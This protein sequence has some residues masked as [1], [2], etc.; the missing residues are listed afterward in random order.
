MKSRTVSPLIW[1]VASTAAIA[2]T[3]L[4]AR[5]PIDVNAA[6]IPVSPGLL[7]VCKGT[8]FADFSGSSDGRTVSVW[9]TDGTSSG[10][11]KL[12]DLETTADPVSVEC[13]LVHNGL[14]YF[15]FIG[16]D[17][18]AALWRTD[19]TAAG[20]LRL[21]RQPSASE[22]P[23]RLAGVLATPIFV[24]SIGSSGNELVATDGTVQGTRL[25]A[26]I[27]NGPDASDIGNEFAIR[28][29]RLYFALGAALWTTDGT[30]AGTVSVMSLATT[31]DPF[32]QIVQV[33]AIN[34]VIYALSREQGTETLWRSDG[35]AG[36]TSVLL[37][38]DRQSEGFINPDFMGSPSGSMIFML[39]PPPFAGGELWRTDG[40]IAGTN[41][42]SVTEPDLSLIF[43]PLPLAN[44]ELAFIGRTAR[45]GDELWI[46]DG[47]DVGTRLVRDL[48]PGPDGSNI[49]NL[50]AVGTGVM[51]VASN[52]TAG[53]APW[54]SDGTAS[55]TFDVGSLDTRL[56]SFGFGSVLQG[57]IGQD[58]YF[59]TL[60]FGPVGEIRTSLLWRLNPSTRTV[61]VAAQLSGFGP[62]LILSSL[63]GRLM[64]VWDDP[65]LGQELWASDGTPGGTT[66]VADLAPQTQ[67]GNADPGHLF[68]LGDAVIYAGADGVRTR[69]LWRSDGTAGGTV[70]VAD[71]APV[72]YTV[73]PPHSA[74]FLGTRLVY[75]GAA[76]AN[77][78]E[79]WIT[80]GTS[81]GT[82]RLT[83]VTVAD[84][85]VS[86][87]FTDASP[88]AC[89]RGF[90]A[91]GG[92]VYFGATV[93]RFGRLYR[94]DGTPIGTT[95]IGVYPFFSQRLFNER[96][97]V[98]P[99]ASLGDRIF[100][101]ASDPGEPGE[102]LWRADLG[103]LNAE[104][105]Q[106]TS[107]R[108]LASPEQIAQLGTSLYFYTRDSGSQRGWWRVS[109]ATGAAE[110]VA[111]TPP[112]ALGQPGRIVATV[113]SLIYFQECGASQPC[114]LSRT[115]GTSA[116]TFALAPA[117]F[118][119]T[120]GSSVTGI[121]GTQILFQ[122]ATDG[123]LWITDGTR[124]GTRLLF[125]IDVG[126]GPSE[127][128]SFVN[129]RGLVYFVVRRNLAPGVTF[130]LWRTDGTAANTERA[131]ALPQYS[132][133]IA[134]SGPPSNGMVTAGQRL[135]LPLYTEAS[136][137]ELWNVENEAPVAQADA[138]TSAAGN[139][140]TV[141]VLANDRDNDGS[142]NRA[143]VRIVQA[144]TSGTT[145]IDNA[146][147][148]IRFTP[149]AS[150][151]GTITF[152]YVVADIQ[153]RESAPA[154]VTVTVTAPPPSGGGNGGS[155]G[156]GGGGA[157]D[158]FSL[159]LLLFA[160]AAT[161]NR[162]RAMAGFR[163]GYLKSLA[164]CR[165]GI[166]SAASPKL[167]LTRRPRCTAGRWP[168]WSAQRRT[169]VYS[170]T[171]RNSAAS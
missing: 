106:T 57:A 141:D 71:A 142:L 27:V 77:D 170:C 9:R 122:G 160:T 115:D 76:I 65:Q 89:G 7:P 155:G 82:I 32:A 137:L 101:G 48:Q 60:P 50:T 93:N 162:E 29:S 39:F 169:W 107:G 16:T 51:F 72:E 33:R 70:R 166:C 110:L 129:F 43:S 41:K 91:A 161:L 58:A 73:F 100:F 3:F 149:A 11:R 54:Y 119:Y 108:N 92:F 103:G 63:G 56:A 25:I 153:Q 69:G 53:F 62:G 67:T 163:D 94:T 10:T 85:F 52:T 26:E 78:N 21:L 132:A 80:D 113:G 87:G 138:V 139:A 8:N 157:F 117:N 116:G 144:P 143:T 40:T 36:G 164:S 123:E 55:G 1:L 168:I 118:D 121:V 135:F 35:T 88:G 79:V 154:T 6:S 150:F 102:F 59:W 159:C 167:R 114:T 105:V 74:E 126:A 165:S 90:I 120:L 44:G 148:A 158:L 68:V 81:P 130:E 134:V 66:L 45:Y 152:T 99:L 86:T 23:I 17:G 18:I 5:L 104:R 34:S 125:D 75:A 13:L 49:S 151:S 156:G 20:T 83:D 171:D 111:E 4:P 109:S 15:Q 96:S 128:T 31:A 38:L 37:S 22:G 97:R 61:G 146:T 136:G 28:N 24:A 98:C 112:S 95:E 64:F 12:I 19:G 2:A 46:T 124:A 131:N 30:A 133:S 47:T 147:G 145:Q 42:I 14:A 140:I 84:P 127:P